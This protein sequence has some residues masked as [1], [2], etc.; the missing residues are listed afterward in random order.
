LKNG[1]V[2]FC[3]SKGSGKSTSASILSSLLNG[4]VQELA[5]AQHL[6]EVCS[7]VFRLDMKYFL[8]PKLKEVELDTY[9]L[10]NKN[11]IEEV[12]KQFDVKDFD[13]DKHIRPHINQVL[14]KPRE[15]LQYMGTDVLHPIDPLIHAKITLAQKDPNRLTVITDLRFESEFNYLL[16]NF[17]DFIPCYVKNAY[18][19]IAASVDKHPSERDLQKFKNKCIIIEN[20]SDI[21]ALKQ[22]IKKIVDER[23][24]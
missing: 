7:G 14:I 23:L 18:A 10:L 17:K 2:A 1:I 16:N 13:Y 24:L 9:I 6:K 21:A 8:D 4:N 3:G 19:E 22:S 12:L 5:F 20:N 11:S 15:L